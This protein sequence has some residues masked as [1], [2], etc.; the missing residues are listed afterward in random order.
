MGTRVWLSDGGHLCPACQMPIRRV[1]PLYLRSSDDPKSAECETDTAAKEYDVVHRTQRR[2]LARLRE[3]AIQRR[4]VTELTRTCAALHEQRARKLSETDQ[5]ERLFPGFVDRGGDSHCPSFS[6][7]SVPIDQ[8]GSSEIEL[9]IAQTTPRLLR[10]QGDLRKE[11]R[12]IERLKR[13]LTSLRSLYCSTKEIAALDREIQLRRR[14]RA[15][16]QTLNT[17][18]PAHS[19]E[20]SGYEQI[21]SS[22][23]QSYIPGDGGNG[24]VR[25]LR[26]RRLLR[27]GVAIINVD[28]AHYAPPQ[29]REVVDVLSAEEEEA[30]EGSEDQKPP[31]VIDLDAEDVAVNRQVMDVGEAPSDRENEGCSEMV[32]LHD[33]QPLDDED[34]VSKLM[35]IPCSLRNSSRTHGTSITANCI[36]LLP[37]YEDRLWQPSLPF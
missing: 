1:T 21:D 23:P 35:L 13:K 2:A 30:V 29:Q 19:E 8:M 12:C 11:R 26:R 6:G 7:A 36:R 22:P 9:Y 31:Y 16:L 14:G 5:E 15:A 28:E 33:S 37:R 4:T 20:S 27:G 24:A 17:R 3:M 32:V 34:D 10:A 18:V 25:A